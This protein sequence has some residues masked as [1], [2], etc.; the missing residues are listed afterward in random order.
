M[1]SQIRMLMMTMKLKTSSVI[2]RREAACRANEELKEAHDDDAV[3]KQDLDD[4]ERET[5]E[6]VIAPMLP[7]CYKISH[8]SVSQEESEK[9]L[10]G[11]SIM[12]RADK[13]DEWCL[14]LVR[15]GWRAGSQA[16]CE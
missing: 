2:Q 3:L 7:H 16:P 5:A 6:S 11:K 10:V 15:R 4:E 14:G 12:H 8:H 13:A 9:C 1:L